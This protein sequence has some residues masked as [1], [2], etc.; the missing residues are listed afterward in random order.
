M[1][2]GGITVE[3]AGGGT[4]DFGSARLRVT[5]DQVRHV[6]EGRSLYVGNGN[7]ARPGD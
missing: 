1:E 4:T 3:T 6:A 2:E 5:A 7:V